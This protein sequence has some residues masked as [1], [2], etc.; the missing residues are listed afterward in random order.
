M[1]KAEAIACGGGTAV[2]FGEGG[3]TDVIAEI[4]LDSPA[5][6]VTKGGFK[7]MRAK[8]DT[9]GARK[10]GV[11]K[12]VLIKDRFGDAHFTETEGIPQQ[13]IYQNSVVAITDW[14]FNFTFNRPM[15]K[16]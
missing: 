10:T 4:L 12:G 9:N 3:P 15:A 14:T 2:M 11:L 1:L 7:L 13:R 5:F 16:E 6:Q 8:E